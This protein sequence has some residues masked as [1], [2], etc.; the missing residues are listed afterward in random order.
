MRRRQTPLRLVPNIQSTP[1]DANALRH[2]VCCFCVLIG[3]VVSVLVFFL[4]RSPFCVSPGSKR[5][6]VRSPFIFVGAHLEVFTGVFWRSVVVT[7]V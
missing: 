3:K 7:L 6:F 2:D 4:T 5:I 1:D